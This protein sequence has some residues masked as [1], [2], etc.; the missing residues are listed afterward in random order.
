[1]LLTHKEIIDAAPTRTSNMTEGSWGSLDYPI[2][3]GERSD[4]RS[5]YQRPHFPV[6]NMEQFCLA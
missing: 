1:M 5:A 2:A 6:V 4:L 3:F